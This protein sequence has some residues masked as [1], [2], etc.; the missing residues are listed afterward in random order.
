[1]AATAGKKSVADQRET[2]RDVGDVSGSVAGDVDH[3]EL[4][5]DIADQREY[6]SWNNRYIKALKKGVVTFEKPAWAGEGGYG[7]I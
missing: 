5:A 1:M 3:V 6:I 2:R 7:S 4:D